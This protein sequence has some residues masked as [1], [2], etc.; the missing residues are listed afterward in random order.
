MFD[1]FNDCSLSFLKAHINFIWNIHIGHE[2]CLSIYDD[3]FNRNITFYAYFGDESIYQC[4]RLFNGRYVFSIDWGYYE[5]SVRSH[6]YFLIWIWYSRCCHRNCH[7]SM[8]FSYLCVLVF[9]ESFGI[10]SKIT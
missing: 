6:I 4:A 9:K 8:C 7:F 5:F 3:L 2:I 1:C 10:K